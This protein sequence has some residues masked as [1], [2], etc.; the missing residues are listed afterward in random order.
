M[1]PHIKAFIYIFIIVIICIII[2]AFIYNSITGD[3]YDPQN[4]GFLNSLYTSVTIQ[5]NIGM[6]DQPTTTALKY[7]IMVQSFLSYTITLGFAYVFLKY[8]MIDKQK[9]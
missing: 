1:D 7:W 9:K 4:K 8:I 5:T 3:D 2:F 6:K